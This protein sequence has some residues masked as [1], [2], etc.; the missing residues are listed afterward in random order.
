M[1]PRI[2]HE[3]PEGFLDAH[4]RDMEAMLGSPA[5]IHIPGRDPRPLFVSTLLHGNEHSGL[6]AVQALVK[7]YREKG[8]ELPRSILLFIGNVRAAHRHCR[9]MPG[10]VDYNRVWDGDGNS[11]EHALARFVL[12]YAREQQPFAC[13]D[14]HN[15][16]GANPHYGCVNYLDK[17]TLTLAGLFSPTLVYFT[18][19]HEVL[20]NAF[21]KFCP[22]ITVEC[23]L[24]AEWHGVEHAIELVDAALNIRDLSDHRVDHDHVDVYETVVRV[25]LPKHAL[26]DFGNDN[27]QVD[28]RFAEN[29]E[30]LNFVEQP[31]DAL[32][33]WRFN[34]ELKLQIIDN[35]GKDVADEFIYYHEHEIRMKRDA[36]P[37]M[38]TRDKQAVVTDCLG[39][40]MLRRTLPEPLP[41][42]EAAAQAPS[43]A[44]QTA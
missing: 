42:R 12:D 15:N 10:Q 35:Q 44:P 19:P 1:Q 32:L 36:V 23:G 28:F 16:T 22:S 30:Y 26:F 38:F 40:F 13:I 31:K 34:H 5:L 7:K 24:S 9:F 20:S 17:E 41:S 21:G 27:S 3:L 11:E 14:I 33:G 4:P 39:Y 43:P 18:E 2:F 25:K 8:K 37:S 6:I 29:F